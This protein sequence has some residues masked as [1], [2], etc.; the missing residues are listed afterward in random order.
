M[1]DQVRELAKLRKQAAT[2]KRE[3]QRMLVEVEEG[4]VKIVMRGDQQVERVEVEGEERGDLKGAFNK[5][6]KESQKK[7]AKKLSGTLSGMKLP[8]L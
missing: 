7:V 8:N 6:V 4:D 1:F 2:L 3:M 5:A